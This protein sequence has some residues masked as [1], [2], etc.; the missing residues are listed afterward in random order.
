MSFFGIT[1]SGVLVPK[2]A[3]V[4][5]LPM[6][7]FNSGVIRTGTGWASGG[8]SGW[9]LN[10]VVPNGA[11]YDDSWALM[12]ATVMPVGTSWFMNNVAYTTYYIGTNGYITF[13]TGI[14]SYSP[15]QIY[16]TPGLYPTPI[17][18]YWGTN[19]ANGT[20]NTANGAAFRYGTTSLGYNFF[21]VNLQCYAYGATG[22]DRSWEIN[23]FYN[24]D[25][26]VQ[27][28]EFMYS[29]TFS[30][31]TTQQGV[32][33]N[34]VYAGSTL[35]SASTSFGWSSSDFGVT[36]TFNGTGSFSVGTF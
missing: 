24:A 26:S 34:A 8:R 2:S 25:N 21:S 33:S 17:D 23:C 28:V 19:G 13:G 27:A 9:T 11:N 10:T 3:P 31:G 36:W 18:N 30:N 14:T 1:A 29:S 20:G 15:A 35:P 22:T 7:T 12:T 6:P 32:Y 16:T 5:G 4:S